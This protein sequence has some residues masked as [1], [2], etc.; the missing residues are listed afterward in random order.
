ML[1]FSKSSPRGR[2]VDVKGTV[3]L[4]S[5]L[6]CLMPC[7]A[8]FDARASRASCIVLNYNSNLEAGRSA[9]S[10]IGDSSCRRG[11]VTISCD[12]EHRL[13]QQDEV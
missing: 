8:L 1:A 9:V 6:G 5:E 13:C 12:E 2:G 11:D 7:P 4:D 10:H 3:P